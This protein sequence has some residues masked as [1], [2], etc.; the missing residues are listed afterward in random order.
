MSER[1][2]S[3]SASEVAAVRAACLELA[4]SG[5]RLLHSLSY[6]NHAWFV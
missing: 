3:S 6:G 2:C 4:C 5:C 1:S